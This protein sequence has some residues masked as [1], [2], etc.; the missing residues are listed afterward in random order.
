M[1]GPLLVIGAVTGPD[2]HRGTVGG[3]I[4]AEAGLATD[5]GAVSVEVPQLVAAAVAVIDLYP[6][7]CR[8]GVAW[9][10]KALVALDLQFAVGEGGPLLIATAVA[11][12]DVQQRA[13][14]CG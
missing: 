12:P 4:E 14:G 6:G 8:C 2:L 7:A 13:V 10:V 9:Y 1:A 11:V 3:H 5:D